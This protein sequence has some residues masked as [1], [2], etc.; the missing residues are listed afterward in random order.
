MFGFHGSL[1][2][3]LFL[4]AFIS[5]IIQT[6]VY[7]VILDDGEE[8]CNR[9]KCLFKREINDEELERRKEFQQKLTRHKVLSKLVPQFYIFFLE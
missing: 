6:K 7:R 1:L 3:N 2:N 8:E 4:G 9:R 5:K